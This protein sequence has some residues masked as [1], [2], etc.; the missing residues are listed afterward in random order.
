MY[1]E[2]QVNALCLSL[3]ITTVLYVC[4]EGI[5]SCSSLCGVKC[6]FNAEVN[7]RYE[8]YVLFYKLEVSFGEKTFCSFVFC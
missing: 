8:A 1:Y 5:L 7:Q 3:F 4:V 6:E 2:L